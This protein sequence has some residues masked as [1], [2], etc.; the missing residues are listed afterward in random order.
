MGER[1]WTEDM[2]EI[3]GFGGSCE[4]ACRHMVLSGLDWLR[5][6][7]GEVPKLEEFSGVM[8]FIDA[9]NGAGKALLDHVI[10]AAKEKFGELPTGAMLHAS[11]SHIM[12]AHKN[13]GSFRCDHPDTE[14]PH[15]CPFQ[16]DIHN[17]PE[18]RCHCC[19]SCTKECADGI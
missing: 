14:E 10:N 1:I 5:Q 11:A 16:E 12:F 17:D 19:A 4:A 8:G 13:G 9:K 3:S 6:Q 15:G 7:D 18:F 2:G